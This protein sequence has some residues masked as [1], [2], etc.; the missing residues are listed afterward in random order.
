MILFIYK[1]LNSAG[2]NELSQ[3]PFPVSKSAQSFSVD[4]F[5]IFKS[6]GG[7]RIIDYYN[8]PFEFIRL[9]FWNS[10]DAYEKWEKHPLTQNYIKTRRIY[11]NDNNIKTQLSGPFQSSA[12]E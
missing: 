11:H 5:K 7:I 10:A 9:S 4:N 8:S 3:L 1:E 2:F 12:Y 6:L